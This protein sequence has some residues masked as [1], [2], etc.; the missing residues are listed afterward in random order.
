M[1]NRKKL[2]ITKSCGRRSQSN[3]RKQNDRFNFSTSQIGLQLF[4][5]LQLDPAYSNSAMSN[6]QLFLI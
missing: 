6:F 4:T 1:V 3:S 5:I 2:T